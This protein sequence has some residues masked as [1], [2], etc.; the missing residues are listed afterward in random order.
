MAGGDSAGGAKGRGRALPRTDAD[1]GRLARVTEGDVD[2]AAGSWR[3]NA[4]DLAGL[5]DA[6]DAD[7]AARAGAKGSGQS[8]G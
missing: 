6:G 5:I 4:G 3:D 1:L 2:A 7:A 8:G